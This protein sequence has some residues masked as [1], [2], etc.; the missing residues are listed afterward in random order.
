MPSFRNASLSNIQDHV[1]DYSNKNALRDTFLEFVGATKS[2]TIHHRQKLSSTRKYIVVRV[3]HTDLTRC[4]NGFNN[5]NEFSITRYAFFLFE[6]VFLL[7]FLPPP[8]SLT[9]ASTASSRISVLKLVSGSQHI[10][11]LVAVMFSV[12]HVE[13]M[14]IFAVGFQLCEI[15]YELV[16]HQSEGSCGFS[17]VRDIS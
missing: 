7:L 13:N 10:L 4:Q 3:L 17:I 9:A 8:L 2:T 14:L 1:G 16:S 12:H 11:K 15:F 6:E 5:Y